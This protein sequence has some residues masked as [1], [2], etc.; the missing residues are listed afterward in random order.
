MEQRSLRHRSGN[1]SLT[2]VPNRER[3][4]EVGGGGGGHGKK[5]ENESTL[6]YGGSGEDS[7]SVYIQSSPM[8]ET[9]IN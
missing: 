3:V 9:T 5:A 1:V 6:F 4:A 7:R 2:S 8:R